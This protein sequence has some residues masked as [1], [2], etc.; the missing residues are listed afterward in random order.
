MSS[1]GLIRREITRDGKTVRY[2]YVF[3]NACPY[4]HAFAWTVH[5]SFDPA[6]RHLI[7]V[8]NIDARTASNPRRQWEHSKSEDRNHG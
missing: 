4:W 7:N 8:H 1:T 5:E 3:C 6:E 2:V